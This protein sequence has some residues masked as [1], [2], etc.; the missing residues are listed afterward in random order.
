MEELDDDDVMNPRNF[1]NN[2]YKNDGFMKLKEKL[3]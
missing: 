3:T 1:M 2:L